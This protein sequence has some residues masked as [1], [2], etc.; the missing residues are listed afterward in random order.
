MTDEA[1]ATNLPLMTEL[2]LV[3]ATDAH[4]V[5]AVRGKLDA[6]GAG[7]IESKITAETVG[8]GKPAVIDLT[9]VE[10][11]G[12]IGIGLLVELGHAMR[13]EGLALAVVATGIV[14]EILDRV[15]IGALFPVV[16]TRDEALRAL[17]V[18]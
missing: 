1:G 14:K 8:R 7:A 11:I 15:T 3:E 12:S 10:L 18:D 2:S 9:G 17:R 16:T 6:S 13:G 4:T 5:V